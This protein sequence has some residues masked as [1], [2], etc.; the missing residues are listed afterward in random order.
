MPDYWWPL[1]PVTAQWPSRL[2]IQWMLSSVTAPAGSGT[3][4]HTA[5]LAE[6]FSWFPCWTQLNPTSRS[7]NWNSDGKM[8]R[9]LLSLWCWGSALVTIQPSS[10]GYHPIFLTMDGFCRCRITWSVI[11]HSLWQRGAALAFSHYGT[12][13]HCVHGAAPHET[14]GSWSGKPVL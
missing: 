2:G 7:Q 5:D 8:L 3:S 14:A 11:Q 1:V 10:S 9:T 4:A 12:P 6:A 13:E